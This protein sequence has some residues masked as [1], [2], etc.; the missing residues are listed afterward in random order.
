M[1]PA[2]A[3][4]CHFNVMYMPCEWLNVKY[5]FECHANGL[6]ETLKCLVLNRATHHILYRRPP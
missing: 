1:F 5:E 3:F 4:A 2:Y 6:R